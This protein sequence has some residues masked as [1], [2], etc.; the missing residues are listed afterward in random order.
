LAA[1]CCVF[2]NTRVRAN[3]V[4]AFRVTRR[5]RAHTAGSS[6]NRRRLVFK[7]GDD[8]SRAAAVAIHSPRGRNNIMPTIGADEKR[9]R[10]ASA[11][12]ADRYR[13]VTSQREGRRVFKFPTDNSIS[14]CG[15]RF[16]R[17]NYT[18]RARV[19]FA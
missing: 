4:K 12:T 15:Q 5:P 17:I 3:G 2:F 16:K 10:T 18:R 13:T 11:S 6:S 8:L 19:W 9:F 1:D 14:I 7:R